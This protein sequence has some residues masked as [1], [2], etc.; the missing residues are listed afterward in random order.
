MD[1]IINL[2]IKVF[3]FKNRLKTFEVDIIFINNINNLK[4]TIKI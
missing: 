1:Y 3:L 2:I 4:K